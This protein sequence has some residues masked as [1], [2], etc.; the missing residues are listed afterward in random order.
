MAMKGLRHVF[1]L[2]VIRGDVAPPYCFEGLGVG[3]VEVL[4][5]V[6]LITT[7]FVFRLYYTDVTY[8]RS[9]LVLSSL[10]PQQNSELCG[11]LF[12]YHHAKEH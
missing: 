6:F 5:G 4:V 7:A 2:L 11:R 1:V 8:L 3:L 10:P 12:W 9:S